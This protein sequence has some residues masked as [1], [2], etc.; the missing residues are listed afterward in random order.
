MANVNNLRDLMQLIEAGTPEE[1]LGCHVPVLW[2][3]QLGQMV[4]KDEVT[5]EDA[6]Q[7]FSERFE[8]CRTGLVANEVTGSIACGKSVECGNFSREVSNDE[9]QVALAGLGK[10]PYPDIL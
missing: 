4:S 1:C 7:Q 9:R 8:G 5:L 10:G 2:A 6:Q 3:N